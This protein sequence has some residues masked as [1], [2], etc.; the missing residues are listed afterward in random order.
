M[1]SEHEHPIDER[2]SAW[3]DG[4]HG[5]AASDAQ[6]MSSAERRRLVDLQWIDAL[7]GHAAPAEAAATDRSVASV[8]AQ[9]ES[10]SRTP[11]RKTSRRPVR[12]RR[13]LPAISLSSVALAAA[14]LLA[15]GFWW[16]RSAEQAMAMVE[17]SY[18]AALAPRDR[19][20]SVLVERTN[21]TMR[22]ITAHLTVRGG[23]KFLFEKQGPLGATI[24]L[25]TDGVGYWFIPPQGPIVRANSDEFL[26]GWMRRTSTDLP[27]LQ[28]ST[29]LERMRDYYQLQRLPAESLVPGGPELS[30]LKA[31][32]SA[33]KLKPSKYGRTPPEQVELWADPATGVVEQLVLTLPIDA[34]RRQA[35]EVTLRLVEERSL[36]DEA[37]RAEYYAPER[38]SVMAPRE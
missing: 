11:K 10:P 17:L 31:T 3:L 14:L 4:Q 12:F 27:H 22:P 19:T 20:Y 35:H 36:S 1:S 38:D 13:L 2:A 34:S 18:Q 29:L 5:L 21:G 37:Y 7:L 30:H 15:V 25:G 16:Q 28:V 23:D 33:G 6:A 32:W 9:L 26:P 24:R 8:L